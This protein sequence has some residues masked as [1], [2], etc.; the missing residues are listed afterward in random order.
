MVACSEVQISTDLLGIAKLNGSL[1]SLRERLQRVVDEHIKTTTKSKKL[2]SGTLITK[3]PIPDPLGWIVTMWY[4]GSDSRYEYSGEM[5]KMT[6]KMLWVYFIK[7]TPKNL[8]IKKS[9][10][11]RRGSRNS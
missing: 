1:V 8:K 9:Q 5:F 4:F 2:S 7:Y 6:W 11:K 10:N 3:D